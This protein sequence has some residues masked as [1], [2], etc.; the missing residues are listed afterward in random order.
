MLKSI[1]LIKEKDTY[2]IKMQWL[3]SVQAAAM[4]GNR[5]PGPAIKK[6]GSAAKLM[7]LNIKIDFLDVNY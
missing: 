1:A 3:T 2:S 5:V 7:P 6:A 4:A